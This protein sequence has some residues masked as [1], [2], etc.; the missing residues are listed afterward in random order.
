LN[1]TL[2]D[3]IARS[4]GVTLAA[5]IYAAAEPDRLDLAVAAA[6]AGL[7]IHADVI[8][9][10]GVRRGVSLEQIGDLSARRLGPLDVHLITEDLPPILEQV[11]RIPV[12]RIT[13][14][15]EACA[16]VA[17]AAEQ[18]RARGAAPW[19]A[20][21]PG[22]D[23]DEVLAY[24]PQVDGVL[25][26]LIEP[27]TSARADTGLRHKV[28]AVAQHTT[29]GVDGGVNEANLRTYLDAS[30]RYVVSGRGL[31]APDPAGQPIH[32]GADAP[33]T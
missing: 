24:L 26:M 7:W 12:D 9:T 3:E 10:G 6:D 15:L 16:D 2:L 20:V 5:S 13:V 17:A 29:A 30:A 14:P 33:Q 28:T 18:I 27:G 11:C 25:V 21:A 32:R 19:L 1:R 4:P 31:L 22:T 23:A 8:V